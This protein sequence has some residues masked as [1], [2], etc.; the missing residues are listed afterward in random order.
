MI[1]IFSVLYFLVYLFLVNDKISKSIIINRLFLFAISSLLAGGLVAFALIPI[2][3]SLG[4]ISAT[5]DAWP[6]SQ[7]YSFTI[8]EFIYN[9]WG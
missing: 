2:F 8:Y 1:C 6:T 3:S 4:S 5:S 9:H 7:Y